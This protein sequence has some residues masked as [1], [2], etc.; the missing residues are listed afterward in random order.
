MQLAVLIILTLW[1]LIMFCFSLVIRWPEE[2]PK[3]KILIINFFYTFWGIII[4]VVPGLGILFLIAAMILF[5]IAQKQ[6]ER[7]LPVDWSPY[8][9]LRQFAYCASF[10]VW[11]YVIA[12]F[13]SPYAVS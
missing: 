7:R 10:L 11:G 4:G 6:L 2:Y 3:R 13:V 12:I 8:S 9:K 1:V 5:V